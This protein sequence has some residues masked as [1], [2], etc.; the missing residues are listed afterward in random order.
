MWQAQQ[1][2]HN[3]S[4]SKKI[5]DGFIQGREALVSACSHQ[6]SLYATA[7]TTLRT[8]SQVHT[9]HE[10]GQLVLSQNF[11]CYNCAATYRVERKSK[12]LRAFAQ[13]R[14]T[15]GLGVM[16]ITDQVAT[17]DRTVCSHRPAATVRRA[18][19]IYA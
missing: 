14:L 4:P 2:V 15:A 11:S 17:L 18:N 9:V 1:N 6:S 7:R 13:S 3:Q 8:L 5:R 19:T 16:L 12:G 10:A